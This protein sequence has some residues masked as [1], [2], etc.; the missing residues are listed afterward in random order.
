[1]S[2]PQKSF[3]ALA[4]MIAF[5]VLTV[6]GQNGHNFD[7]SGIDTNA[8]ACTD[9]YQYANGNW[10]AKNPI[11]GAFPSW[12]VANVLNERIAMRCA[13][14]SRPLPRIRKRRKAAANKK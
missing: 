3:T 9:F 6:F 2:N 8:S 11:P 13:K 10:L 1:M 4:L 12:G 5:G 7:V 14:F